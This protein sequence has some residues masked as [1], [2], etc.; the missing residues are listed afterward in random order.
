MGKTRQLHQLRELICVIC[1]IGG[2]FLNPG[3]GNAQTFTQRGFLENRGTF[4]PQKAPNDAAQ[5]VGESL[6]RYEVFYKPSPTFE[7]AGAV[8]LRIDTHHQTERNFHFS[9]WDRETR[10][11]IGEVRRLSG[12][13]HNGPVTFEVGKQFIRWG[14]T[15]IVTPTDRFAPRD[16]LTVVDNA[17][18]AVTAARLNYEKGS[19][20]V[21]AVWSPRLTPSRIPLPDQRWAPPIQ[22]PAFV[23]GVR[24]AGVLFPGGRNRVFDGIT[25]E[26]LSMS[27]RFIRASIISRRSTL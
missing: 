5:S 8:D 17:F 25:L 13:Y 20:T 2:Y 26:L 19:N 27:F 4:Y 15:D 16:F 9:W 12:T 6:F 22:L 3:I 10:R 24:D 1:V 21:E 14:K 23:T 7:I 18:L 11:P